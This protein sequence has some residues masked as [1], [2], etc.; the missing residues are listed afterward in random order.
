MESASAISLPLLP[1]SL[2]HPLSSTL[3]RQF[4]GGEFEVTN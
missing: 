3:F 4:G 2:S 1:L